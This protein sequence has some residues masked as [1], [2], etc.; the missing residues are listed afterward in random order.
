LSHTPEI[1]ALVIFQ[2]ASFVFAGSCL[3]TVI[4]LISAS[5]VAGI[6][7]MSHHAQL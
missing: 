5:L 4:P 2:V 7:D 6:T 1:F 3:R